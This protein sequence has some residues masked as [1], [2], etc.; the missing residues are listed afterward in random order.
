MSEPMHPILQTGRS[1]IADTCRDPDHNSWLQGDSEALALAVEAASE[2]EI[3]Q[4]ARKLG[5]ALM[6]GGGYWES[7]PQVA[8]NI[9]GVQVPTPEPELEPIETAPLGPRSR[10]SPLAADD[11]EL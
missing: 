2:D 5:D 9:L 10:Q 3:G 4:I 6:N 11:L 7:L 8:E 1:E